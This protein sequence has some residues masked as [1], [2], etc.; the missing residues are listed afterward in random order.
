MN[1]IDL[2]VCNKIR[3]SFCTIR[4]IQITHKGLGLAPL[5]KALCAF[6]AADLLSELFGQSLWVGF[7]EREIQLF[8]QRGILIRLGHQQLGQCVGA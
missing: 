4:G 5:D 7:Y 8:A 6:N 1:R 2:T 3:S